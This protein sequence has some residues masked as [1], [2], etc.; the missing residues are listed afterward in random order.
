MA[1]RIRVFEYYFICATGDG[2]GR[3]RRFL[4]VLTGDLQ[5]NLLD[6]VAHCLGNAAV[7]QRFCPPSSQNSLALGDTGQATIASDTGPE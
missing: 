3:H 1:R 7:A 2:R 5:I 4:V 6:G